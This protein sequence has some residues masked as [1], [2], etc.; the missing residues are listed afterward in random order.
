MSGKHCKNE[1]KMQILNVIM[2][3]KHSLQKLVEFGI[4]MVGREW[5]I[6]P[7]FSVK[8]EVGTSTTINDITN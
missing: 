8:P 6:L 1:H 5:K 3:T 7:T 2:T 4:C